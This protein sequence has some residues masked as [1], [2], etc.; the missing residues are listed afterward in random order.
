MGVA[1]T[2]ILLDQLTAWQKEKPAII[3]KNQ[4][5]FVSVCFKNKL[6]T[7]PINDEQNKNVQQVIQESDSEDDYCFNILIN[8]KLM[9]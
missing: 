1:V 7:E 3:V 4:I 9:F 8:Q 2:V 5:T 6:K